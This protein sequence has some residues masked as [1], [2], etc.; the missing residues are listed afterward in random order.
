MQAQNYEQYYLNFLVFLTI[1][2]IVKYNQYNDSR[3]VNS[4]TESI[5]PSFLLFVLITLYIGYRP[6]SGVFVDTMNYKMQFDN[7][8]GIKSFTPKKDKLFGYFMHNSAQ[9]MSVSDWF[10]IIATVYFGLMLA[11]IRRLF[12]QDT[13]FVFVVTLSA[14][15]CFAYGTNGL[16]NGMATSV[17][18][19]AL[20]FRNKKLIALS[21]LLI[22]SGIHMSLLLTLIAAIISFFYKN[23]KVYTVSWILAIF[24]SFFISGFFENF[25]ASFISDGRSGYLTLSGSVYGGRGGFRWDFLMYSSMPVLVGYYF[26]IIKEFKDDTYKWILNTYL[27]NNAFWILVIRASFSNRFAYLSWFLYPLVLIY[28][29]LKFRCIKN[30][31]E[32][33]LLVAFLHILF[34][35]IMML[36]Y[37]VRYAPETPILN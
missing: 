9:I 29:F 14:F 32:K 30:Q 25:F 24:L 34:S 26:V 31:Y 33:T 18:M 27:I 23:T 13:F 16:R 6:L 5:L 7:L 36:I 3:I 35:Y 2:L 15:S 21:L 17:A 11:A 8:V 1:L 28:P 37:N 10:T 19:F 12:P 20:T 22:A 4:N